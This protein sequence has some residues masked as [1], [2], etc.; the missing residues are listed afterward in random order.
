MGSKRKELSKVDDICVGFHYSGE[1]GDKLKLVQHLWAGDP[2]AGYE[3]VR[4]AHKAKYP[5][6]KAVTKREWWVF[7]GIIVGAVQFTQ[8]GR[9]LWRVDDGV[10]SLRGHPD[11]GQ[12]MAE[13]RFEE[14]KF[15]ASFC[16]ADLTRRTSD[17][18]WHIRGGV[19]G[20]NENRARTVKRSR[21]LCIDESMSGFQPRSSKLGGLPHL[22]FIK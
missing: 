17:P 12:Y 4:D 18:W 10:R 5:R 9:A 14:I 19:T 2:Q 7:H 3:Q 22:S 8:R 6:S 11:F 20:L 1:R 13:F 21:A 15:V 16:Y